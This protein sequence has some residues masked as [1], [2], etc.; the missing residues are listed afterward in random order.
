MK[1][2]LRPLSLR[3][4]LFLTVSF[5]PSASLL[6]DSLYWDGLTS[7]SWNDATNWSTVPGAA[8]PDPL[9]A[10]GAGDVI[11]F[12]VGDQ[13]SI[14]T[15]NLLGSQAVQGIVTDAL[16]GTVNLR[17]G[18]GSPVSLTIGAA[19]INH[20]KGGITLG[21]GSV[22]DKVNVIL[23]SSQTWNSS[24][25]GAG[26]AAI[27]VHNDLSATGDYMLTLDG[28]NTGSHIS[29]AI[30]D[31]SGKV[32]IVKQGSGIWE[33]RGD[34]SYTGSTLV[35]EGILRV[36]K[37]T[38]ISPGTVINVE[39]GATFSFGI[40]ASG[41]TTAEVESL[42]GLINFQSSAAYL[43]LDPTSATNFEG[44]ISGT[45][46]LM[47]S[48]SQTL[49]LSGS[50]TYTGDTVIT[51]GLIAYQNQ[52]AISNIDKIYAQAGA[53]VFAFAG[54][55]SISELETLRE[56]IHYADNSSYF[57]VSTETG[58]FDYNTGMVGDHSFV[59][60]GNNT[61]TFGGSDSN[62]YTGTTRVAGGTLLLSK[63]A[64]ATAVAGNVLVTGG[65]LNLGASDQIADTSI[66]TGSGGTI[67]FLAKNE[68]VAGMNLSGSAK[69][70]TGN[71]GGN[72]PTSIVRLGNVTATETSRITVNSGG[73]IIANSLS[74]TGLI[75]ANNVAGNVLLGGGHN[76]VVS[77]LEVGPGGLT[78][79]NRSIQMNAAN[80]G[81][82][83]SRVTLNGTF[84]GSGENLIGLN[85]ASSASLT[86]L[87]LGSEER[88]FNITSG[89]TQID[90]SVA[91]G[92]LRKSGSGTLILAGNNT[93]D[94]LTSIDAGIL[95]VRHAGALGS[96]V[97]ATAIGNGGRL[98]LQGGITVIGETLNVTHTTDSIFLES[99]FAES[100]DGAGKQLNTWSGDINLTTSTNSRITGTSG[101]LL[102]SG[103]IA[104]TGTGAGQLVLQ[105]EAGGEISGAISG[106]R[107]VVK[108]SNDAGTWILSGANT[109]TGNTTISKGTLQLGN[110]GTTGSLRGAGTISVGNADANFTVNRSNKAEEG[111][112]FGK[113]TGSGS[114]TQAGSGTTILKSSNYTGAT[115]INS[116]TLQFATQS[117][118][119]NNVSA[120]WT[121]DKISVASGATLAVNVGGATGFT[122]AN[123]DTIKGLGTA[124]GGFQNGS[125][126][127]IDTTN[128]AGGV[129]SYASPISNTNGGANSIGLTKLGTGT[130]E[131]S[132]V[133][134]YTGTTIV[135]GGSLN[136][137]STGALNGGGSVS[138]ANGASFSL[139]GTYLFNIGENGQNNSISGA[140]SVSLA[141]VFNLNLASASMAD[142]N[143]WS[144]VGISGTVDWA[145]L[146]I[147]S[148]SGDFARS[149]EIWTRVDG[150]NTW[151]FDQSSGLLTL[152]VPEPSQVALLLL[153]LGGYSLR[154]RRN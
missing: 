64:G 149:G 138:V 66:I 92:A 3:P 6:A 114:F 12:S 68:T 126:L 39:N 133:N 99:L 43:G 5:T 25:V 118:L 23:A 33:L 137:T 87:S 148:T 108:S 52:Q 145:D 8:T 18:D 125:R 136:V 42:K 58:S 19:G 146:Q 91:S 78:M 44:N 142:G 38:A 45:H 48:G 122:S 49:T 132:G 36:T 121:A 95:R 20:T 16:T 101:R 70:E 134:T 55:F 26:A 57:G 17:G 129:F 150:A 93:Y 73:K 123:L 22:P 80:A 117:A 15:V 47:K 53:G 109:Y 153:G 83:G 41:M 141:G 86:E 85:G 79:Q 40:G 54:N 113:I 106:N 104:L 13:A 140:G 94:G 28:L 147:T 59:K 77:E 115:R 84:T 96:T 63:T 27:M 2:N 107:N 116:G 135:S 90:I 144:L 21:N 37:A 50:N 56:S 131:L 67:S 97:S 61:L 98:Q 127:G 128:A 31:G 124:T 30:S 103:N 154:R 82:K 89:N 139:M 76:T 100:T 65:T 1:P 119:Y 24:T 32:S 111:V 35:K 81:Q 110:G 152:A 72:N 60:A 71:T 69:F 51:S 102:I 10:P 7:S 151:T 143:Q 46:G 4:L 14:R 29:G 74:L 120:N 75:E 34:N 9:A 11:H 130:L 88:T 62:T 105:G 112:D